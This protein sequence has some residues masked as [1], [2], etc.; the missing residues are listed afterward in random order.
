MLYFLIWRKIVEIGLRRTA[1]IPF[2]VVPCL[3]GVDFYACLKP[4]LSFVKNE[5]NFDRSLSNMDTGNWLYYTTPTNPVLSS[6]ERP[7][8][9][10]DFGCW[11]RGGV[12][13]GIWFM[14]GY[15]EQTNCFMICCLSLSINSAPLQSAISLVNDGHGVTR[16][17]CRYTPNLLWR[18]PKPMRI[19]G[20]SLVKI[21]IER[22]DTSRLTPSAKTVAKNGNIYVNC[23]DLNI[24]FSFSPSEVPPGSSEARPGVDNKRDFHRAPLW[25]RS[26]GLVREREIQ[27]E[28]GTLTQCRCK[29]MQSR[30]EPTFGTVVWVNIQVRTICGWWTRT[31]C[32]S[33]W[34]PHFS[35]ELCSFENRVI[36]VNSA[37]ESPDVLFTKGHFSLGQI[38]IKVVIL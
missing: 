37:K 2:S 17:N 34:S 23:V 38:S 35:L 25:T 16:T 20:V 7:E 3:D 24:H 6:I 27:R 8:L 13:F 29:T 33:K 11:T 32:R 19:G 5:D 30:F 12:I 31:N 14:I 10:F 1:L 26:S 15:F 28:A 36:W 18:T 21:N 4:V 9:S 22:W